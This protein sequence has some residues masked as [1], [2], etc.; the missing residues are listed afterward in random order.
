[1]KIHRTLLIAPLVF[2]LASPAVAGDLR[3]ESEKKA[4]PPQAAEAASG[5]SRHNPAT[6]A[7]VSLFAGGMAVALH[8]FINNKNGSY[9]EFGEANAVN[10]KLGAA[11][12]GT[13]FAGGVLIFVGTRKAKFAP[14]VKAG[15]G[16]V[17]ISKQLTW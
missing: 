3:T 6:W 9:A 4:P 17:T 13:A 12:I 14:D 11:S 5:R 15:L 10:K 16:E 2:A 8:S 1:M 7:G